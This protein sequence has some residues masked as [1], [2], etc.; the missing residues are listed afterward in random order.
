M[1]LKKQII[2]GAPFTWGE[3]LRSDSAVRL[4]LGGEQERP[5]AQVVTNLELLVLHV[6][7]PLR[8]KVGAIRVNSGYRCPELNKKIG[9]SLNSQH[10]TGQAADIEGLEVTN[11]QLAEAIVRMGLPFDQLILEFGTALEPEWIHVSYAH[12]KNRQQVLQAFKLA[13]RTQYRP[14]VLEVK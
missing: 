7:K 11:R 9:G 2:D 1:D 10:V 13:G 5:P 14:I 3:M 12:G 6:L 8:A 4:G